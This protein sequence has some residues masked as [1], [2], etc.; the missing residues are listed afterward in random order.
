MDM[1]MNLLMVLSNFIPIIVVI[2]IIA[3]VK[4]KNRKKKEE[5]E[6]RKAEAERK[7]KEEE[8]R[9]K[10]EE[11]RVRREKCRTKL[12]SE[13]DS[14]KEKY[15]LE[16]GTSRALL[17]VDALARAKSEGGATKSSYLAAACLL[18]SEYKDFEKYNDVL[19]L[20]AGWYRHHDF[21][22]EALPLHKEVYERGDER[23]DTWFFYA[24][25]LMHVS[26]SIS[27]KRKAVELYQKVFKAVVNDPN[28][29][30]LHQMAVLEYGLHS[31]DLKDYG[32]AF[33]ALETSARYHGMTDAYPKL[34]YC[35]LKGLGTE[36]DGDEFDYWMDKTFATNNMRLIDELGELLNRK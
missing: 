3:A 20:L 32:N 36:Y 17:Y 34:A 35:Y 10:E 30:E 4:K 8:K 21:Y 1:L 26:S 27:D 23:P 12:K 19:L 13:L 25:C 29:K 7:R 31:F 24:Y 6:R 9:R 2:I 5:E 15:D 28:K 33:G 14:I 11:A 16:D 22:E 18:L